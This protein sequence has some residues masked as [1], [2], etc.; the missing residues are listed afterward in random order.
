MIQR[1][2]T[3]SPIDLQPA[4]LEFTAELFK[5]PA[6]ITVEADPEIPGLESLVVRVAAAG[7]VAEIVELHSTWHRK[8]LEIA[9]DSAHQYRL[10]LEVA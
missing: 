10:A 3:P 5:N 2:S 1:Q 9:G 7:S 8:V 6:S 4:I